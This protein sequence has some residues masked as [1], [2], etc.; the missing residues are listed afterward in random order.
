MPDCASRT[1]RDLCVVQDAKAHT[2]AH[3]FAHI[4]EHTATA[5]NLG[6]A[7]LWPYVAGQGPFRFRSSIC[8]GRYAP[9]EDLTAPAGCERR[10]CQGLGRKVP[11]PCMN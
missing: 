5:P 11:Q 6:E 2:H 3:T 7:A 1:R 9:P 8:A 10:V 4:G